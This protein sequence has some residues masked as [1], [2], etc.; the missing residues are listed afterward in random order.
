MI[1][2]SEPKDV[3]PGL[4][5]GCTVDFSRSGAEADVAVSAD[6]EAPTVPTARIL[7]NVRL[8]MI[9]TFL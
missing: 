4:P 2:F 3:F 5:T 8:S 7:E 1:C 9:V 6:S